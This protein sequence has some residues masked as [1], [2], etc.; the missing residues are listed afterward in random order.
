[1]TNTN[2]KPFRSLLTA[3]TSNL[4]ATYAAVKSHKMAWLSAAGKDVCLARIWLP[5]IQGLILG[6]GQFR[7]LL[8]ECDAFGRLFAYRVA[9]I[10]AHRMF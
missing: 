9:K 4:N 6:L 10:P 2:S 1:M 5:E 7:V 3:A 8:G